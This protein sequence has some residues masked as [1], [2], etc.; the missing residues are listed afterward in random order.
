MVRLL[1]WLA[2]SLLFCNCGLADGIETLAQSA[3]EKY[4]AQWRLY[5][6]HKTEV[7]GSEASEW[8]EYS[9]KSP[10]LQHFVLR[11]YYGDRKPNENLY[12]IFQTDKY[13]KV[14]SKPSDDQLIAVL[15]HNRIASLKN[16]TKILENVEQYRKNN[17]KA[18]VARTTATIGKIT[19]I[20]IS[21]SAK[22]MGHIYLVPVLPPLAVKQVLTDTVLEKVDPSKIAYF[23][24]I[25]IDA[26]FRGRGPSYPLMCVAFL[27]M[28]QAYNKEYI[29]LE[30]LTTKVTG[31][32]EKLGFRSLWNEAEYK[33]ASVADILSSDQCK[34]L[35]L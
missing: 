35:S 33:Y 21:S 12:Q 5:P 13:G 23:Y 34:K 22:E 3:L 24:E 27:A 18:S 20:K 11:K 14:I 9:L 10:N 8:D 16:Y 25:R 4:T 15:E 28:K 26:D 32:Y 29:V 31:I 7:H 19:A 30:D 1:L 17:V 6:A 2:I